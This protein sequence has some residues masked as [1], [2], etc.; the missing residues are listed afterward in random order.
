MSSEFKRWQQRTFWL[1]W[2]TYASFYLGRV[3]LSVALPGLMDEFGWT[4]T[5]V[6]VIGAAL[7]WAY[8]VGQLVNGFLGDRIGA[9]VM[10]A[11]G[12]AVS[13]LLNL[14]FGFGAGLVGLTVVWG[15]NGYVQAMGWG[16][17]MK[18]MANWFP[19]SERGK[20]AGRM[21]TS[22]ILGG[23]ASVLL[24][25]FIAAQWGWRWT[26]FAPGLLMLVFAA[27]WYSRA[28]NRP[29]DIGFPPVE[30]TAEREGLALSLKR[31][32]GNPTAWVLGAALMFTNVLRYGFLTWAPTYLFETQGAAIDKAAYSS[33]IFPLAGALGAVAAGWAS[34]RWFKSRRA[35]CACLCLAAAGALAYA[36]RVADYWLAGLL[37]L[38]A[39]GATVFGAHVLV[40]G[41]APMD[42]GGRKAASAVT[43]FI[44]AWGYVGAG[45]TG[46]V[47]GLLVDRWGWSAGFN[48][49]ALSAFAGALVMVPLWVRN[50]KD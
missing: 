7:F 16:P 24:A 47:T 5:Q 2:I 6:G 22:Y 43:G 8:A 38:A 35:P 18:T 10:I 13:A 32:L 23:A 46:L 14:A 9:R 29:E 12:L 45:A 42:C 37:L 50:R 30:R 48:F 27:R 19:P 17:V 3:N 49:W 44:D 28:R 40:V 26:F 21:G 31:S 11:A 1:L 25:G 34:D 15:L 36:Y 41:A 4:K 39:T 20:V 33:V